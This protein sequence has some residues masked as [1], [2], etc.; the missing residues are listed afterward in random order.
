M[1]VGNGDAGCDPRNVADMYF[2][3]VSDAYA[4]AMQRNIV[5][6]DGFQRLQMCYFNGEEFEEAPENL[7]AAP[8]N[9][10]SEVFS[11][12]MLPLPTLLHVPP[13]MAEDA[14]EELRSGFADMVKALIAFREENPSGA[15]RFAQDTYF[16]SYK[17]AYREAVQQFRVDLKH[18]TVFGLQVCYYDGEAQP[19]ALPNM[20]HMPA[21]NVAVDLIDAPT[22]LPR[23]IKF[24]DLMTQAQAAEYSRVFE[25]L[26][27]QVVVDRQKIFD[28]RVREARA[29]APTGKQGGRLKIMLAALRTTQVQQFATRDLTRA[30]EQLGHTVHFAIER[31]AME[32]QDGHYLLREYLKFGPDIFIIVNHLRNEWLHP[33]VTCVA[34]YQDKMPPL[35]QG[36]RLAT[37][38]NDQ[39]YSALRELDEPLAV[40]GVP[41]VERQSFCIDGS[42]FY[43]PINESRRNA[44]V[45]VGSSG[46]LQLA[47][48]DKSQAMQDHLIE[49]ITA[50]E[51]FSE[52][53]VYG[54][55]DQMGVER[56]YA[57]W[58]IYYY[59]TRDIIVHWL[60][61]SLPSL[62]VDVEVYGRYWER[63][64][65]VAPFFKG[66]IEHGQP[67]A[68]LYQ[69]VRYSLVC[70]PF[71]INS[72]RLL[73]VGACGCIPIVHDCRSIAIPPHWDE[74]CYFFKT[75]ED[76]RALFDGRRLDKDA[77][78]IAFGRTYRDF[79]ERILR[80]RELQFD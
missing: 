4:T 74:Q 2:L 24:P 75:P 9:R 80:R 12:S 76:L 28:D 40:C 62:G 7:V 63:D 49:R 44:I 46:V 77:T 23:R 21:Q 17:D 68:N 6:V 20:I 66:E 41:N 78:S 43:P 31:N 22:R 1:S 60:C 59:V 51:V 69:G 8:I 34:W 29:L 54:L 42:V 36:T 37:R 5:E 30:F 47:S 55:A 27:K 19:D 50:G 33:D 70:H 61:E 52:Q 32:F 67:L 16:L 35:I 18:P 79:A 14:R 38:S 45:F 57:F 72:Q 71:D 25:D 11:E 10:F 13:G 58:S 26:I 73:E 56:Q 65:V 48:G 3:D 15:F 53:E 39:V 64:P